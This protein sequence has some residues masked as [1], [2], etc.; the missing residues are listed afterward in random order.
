MASS[1]PLQPPRP[2]AARRAGRDL[3]SGPEAGVPA[4]V[5]VT[6]SITDMASAEFIPF[7]VLTL[8]ARPS[9]GNFFPVSTLTRAPVAGASHSAF[10]AALE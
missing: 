6:T 2:A 10:R 8:R 5:L 4:L 9:V 1:R 7:I 3:P